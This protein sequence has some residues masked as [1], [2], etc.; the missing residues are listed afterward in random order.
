[1]KSRGFPPA[2]IGYTADPSHW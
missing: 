1:V 2:Q